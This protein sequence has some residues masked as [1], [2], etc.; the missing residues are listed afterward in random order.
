ML[1]EQ[2]VCN[3]RKSLKKKLKCGFIACGY[4]IGAEEA[5]NERCGIPHTV[6]K[7]HK[8]YWILAQVSSRKYDQIPVS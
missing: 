6:C 2:Y 8:K 1:K 4:S 5:V 3:F 7:P